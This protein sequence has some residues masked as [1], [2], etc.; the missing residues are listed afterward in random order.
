MTFQKSVISTFIEVKFLLCRNI[1]SPIPEYPS[2][3]VPSTCSQNY[4]K[5]THFATHFIAISKFRC[6]MFPHPYFSAYIYMELPQRY[7]YCNYQTPQVSQ[8]CVDGTAILY[9][10][11]GEG[12]ESRCS[13]D[14][15]HPSTWGP[16]TH[17]ASFRMGARSLS[18][19]SVMVLPPRPI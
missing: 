18:R 10:L 11:N 17:P 15:S 8:N 13:Q 1:L 4:I 19:G 14:F 16:R 2:A 9:G 12:I 6:L 5:H 3:D 7:L